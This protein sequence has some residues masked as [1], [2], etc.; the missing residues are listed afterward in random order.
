MTKLNEKRS[1]KKNVYYQF[2]ILIF[3]QFYNFMFNNVDCNSVD[4]GDISLRK[5]R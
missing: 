1:K 4:K 2:E 3:H 5:G